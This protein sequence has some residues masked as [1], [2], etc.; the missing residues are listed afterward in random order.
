MTVVGTLDGVNYS[1]VS[2]NVFYDETN[3]ISYRK[4][5][6][7]DIAT[8]I[9]NN[10]LYNITDDTTTNNFA[11]TD[12]SNVSD[13][14]K[15]LMSGMSMPSNTYT[16]LTLGTSGST[17]TAPANGWY[18]I[19]K[20]ANNTGEWIDINNTTSHY[21]I[22]DQSQQNSKTIR[23]ALPVKVGDVVKISYSLTG[24]TNFFRFIY[25]VGSES[26]AS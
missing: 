16:D 3:E 8:L 15:I 5:D 22:S 25:A 13:D 4:D 20:V 14:A 21:Y 9:D 7:K 6:E 26:E 19:G 1:R 10:T 12:L 24:S 17:Y 18:N 11:D 2:N 23:L